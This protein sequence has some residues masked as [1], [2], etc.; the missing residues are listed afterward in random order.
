[1]AVRRGPGGDGAT[2]ARCTATPLGLPAC[3]FLRCP[4]PGRQAHCSIR[5]SLRRISSPPSK[6]ELHEFTSLQVTG[7]LQHGY[8][9]VV[10]GFLRRHSAGIWS[11]AGRGPRGGAG[12]RYG[13]LLAGARW[14]S[15]AKRKA[16]ERCQGPSSSELSPSRRLRSASMMRRRSFSLAS[17]AILSVSHH[18]NM[19]VKTATTTRMN[20]TAA[21]SRII[22]PNGPEHGDRPYVSSIV[23]EVFD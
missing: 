18:A 17:L 20:A 7:E 3:S 12:P 13:E 16:P 1:M 4:A 21:T 22:P 15:P 8:P 2:Q 9:A 14:R 11:A 5:Q 19:T 10:Y 23:A 6:V